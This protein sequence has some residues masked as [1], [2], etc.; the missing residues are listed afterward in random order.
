MIESI[1]KT[2]RS[3]TGCSACFNICPKAAINMSLI[4]GFYKPCIDNTKCVLCKKC[5][6]VC[7]QNSDIKQTDFKT[8][9]FACK[10]VDLAV[11]MKS[12]SGGIFSVLAEKVLSVKGIV[13]GVAFDESFMAHH[14]RI[15]NDLIYIVRIYNTICNADKQYCYWCKSL[16]YRI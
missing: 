10:N 9:A 11:R 2:G 7:P 3:C 6:F 16:W 14:I 13:Y 8:I 4:N 5:I 1:I 12:A 15:E